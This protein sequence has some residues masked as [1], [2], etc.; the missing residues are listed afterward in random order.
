MISRQMI[1]R[2]ILDRNATLFNITEC[3]AEVSALYFSLVQ[4]CRNLEINPIDYFFHLF[5]NAGG[6]TNGDVKGWTE[7]LP[8]RCDLSDAI[9][10]KELIACAKPDPDRT[11]PYILRGKKI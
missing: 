7:I 5:L 1:R 9:K 10:H 11:E 6:I 8:G 3:G 4:S 2:Y